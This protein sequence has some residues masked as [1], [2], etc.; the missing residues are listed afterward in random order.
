M[1]TECGVMSMWS[2]SPTKYFPL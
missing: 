2:G 1:V